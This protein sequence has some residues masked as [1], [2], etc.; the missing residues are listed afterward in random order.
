M[1]KGPIFTARSFDEYIKMFSLNLNLLKNK[2]IL[3]CAAGASSFAAVMNK[4]GYKVTA[5]DLLY[6][7][8]PQF[9]KEICENHLNVLISALSPFK[10]HFKWNYFKNL[11]E[12]KEHRLIAQTEFL[13]D[14]TKHRGKKYIKADLTK[15]PF[16]DNAFSL[17]LCSHL[18]F[19]Y[20]HRLSYEF[21]LN[22]INEMIRVGDEV[23]I[24]PLVKHKAM[25][26]EFVKQIEHDLMEE[27]D[28]K[29]EK[30]NYEFRLGGNEMMRLIKT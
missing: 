2:N 16:N 27:A 25:K 3:D 9:L 7:K 26:S 8:D 5:L 1:S 11:H 10:H 14:Y 15:L 28:I 22:S 23:R 18:L 12:L 24:Y 4:K 13:K 29:I 20:D 17:V 19:I 30:V 6:D 21:H